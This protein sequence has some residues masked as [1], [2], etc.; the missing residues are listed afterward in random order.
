MTFDK[1]DYCVAVCFFKA[2]RASETSKK[3]KI[4]SHIEQLIFCANALDVQNPG[5]EFVAINFIHN[6]RTHKH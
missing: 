6:F 5:N 3:I 4:I 2:P 1:N